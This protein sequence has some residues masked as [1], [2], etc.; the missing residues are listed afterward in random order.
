MDFSL[1]ESIIENG[2]EAERVRFS[3]HLKWDGCMNWSTEN[4]L[5]YHFCDIE[6]A[7][8]LHQA[9]QKIWDLGP[10]NIKNWLD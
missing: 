4:S 2:K 7:E 8:L 6:D 10:E 9:F 3:G 1:K 5:M